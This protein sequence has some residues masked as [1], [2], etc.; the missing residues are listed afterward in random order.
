MNPVALKKK[1]LLE[2]LKRKRAG[3]ALLQK[4]A[5]AATDLKEVRQ[6]QRKKEKKKK[7]QK[8]SRGTR[9]RRRGSSSSTGSATSP[10]STTS[11]E[12]LFRQ[13]GGSSASL[14]DT[15]RRSPG[16]LLQAALKKM[17]TYLVTREAGVHGMDADPL[18]PTVVAYLTSVLLPSTPGMSI[19][20]ARELQT[21]ATALDFILCG[22]VAKGADVMIQRFQAV[23]LAVSEGSWSISRH[24]ELIAD[25]K[26]SSVPEK[27]K[28]SALRRE[29]EEAKLR[30]REG[31]G[32]RKRE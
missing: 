19:R 6:A 23:E 16:A 4:A 1:E 31:A 7:R 9:R 15:A 3:D 18:S 20:S 25:P 11:V 8:R 30:W 32:V 21:L 29:R 26:V 5:D 13:G 17:R 28:E 22:Q 10:S 14:Q 12:P 24:L 27:V 2:R